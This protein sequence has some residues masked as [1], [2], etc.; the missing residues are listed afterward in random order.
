MESI[1][2]IVQYMSKKASA[3]MTR[4]KFIE[5][6]S[7]PA[8]EL[9]KQ[10]NILPSLIIGV[11]CHESD[12]GESGLTQKANNL[13][14]IKG[15]YENKYVVMPTYEYEDGE[16]IKVDARFRKYPSYRESI[17]DFCELI[18][19]GVSWNREIYHS[20]IGVD[21]AEEVVTLFAKTPYMTDPNYKEKLWGLVKEYSIDRYDAK[22]VTSKPDTPDRGVSYPNTLFR[23]GSRGNYV[24][25]IQQ[26]V[27][28]NVDGIFG[29]ITQAYVM[30][31][32]HKNN[33]VVDGIVGKNTWNRLFIQK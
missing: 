30:V 13:F 26:K 5:E 21:N 24:E 9:G 29:E 6:L 32:Q 14:G 8:K 31:F 25:M 15:A 18:Q 27:G 33:L 4:E 22:T 2:Y 19:N 20:V 16:R 28:C 7:K 10:Y 1:F 17:E 11:A 3:I 12:F 23:I